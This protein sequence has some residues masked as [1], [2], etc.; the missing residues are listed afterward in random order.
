MTIQMNELL[1][2]LGDSQNVTGGGSAAALVGSISASLVKKVYDN[3][4]KKNRH[5]DKEDD[6]QKRMSEL[7]DIRD[8]LL[9]LVTE[10]PKALQPLINAYKLPKNTNEEKEFRHSQIQDAIETAA[11]P[12]V[13]ILELLMDITLHQQYLVGMQ[14][15]G[16]IVTNLAE[17]LLFSRS[18]FEVAHIGART[19][20]ATL[21][22]EEKRN[23]RL[24]HV[25]T[26]MTLGLDRINSAHEAVSLFLESN[27]WPSQ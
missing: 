2:A 18:A 17:S 7:D 22:E 26:L 9:N 14:P 5:P 23:E 16:E 4:L 12:Q 6:I 27:S 20:Y 8:R 13:E 21:S 15:S 11:R 19:N 3:E 10:D 1:Q 25:S 24:D